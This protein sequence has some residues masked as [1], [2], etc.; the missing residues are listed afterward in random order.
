MKISRE[1]KTAILV[2]SGIALLIFL[3]NYLKGENLLDSSRTY[4]AVYDNVE[5]LAPS[6]PVTIN[7]QNVGKVQSIEFKEDGSGKLVVKLLITNDFEFSK[8]STAELYEAGLIGGK[9]VAIVPA[10][11]GASPA[12]SGSY[13]TAKTKEGLSELVNQR[14]TPLQE[15]I[16]M[17]MVSADE[18]IRNINSLFSPQNKENL[19]KAL[20]QL[21]GT[22]ISYKATANGLNKMIAD[23]QE[24]LQSTLSSAENTFGNFS[25]ISDSIAQVDL[26]GAARDLQSSMDNL[27]QLLS[28][29]EQGNGTMGKFLKDEQLYD[30]L[31]GATKQ[32]EELLQDL[33]LNPKRYVHFSVF[34]K[35]ADQYDAEG[36]LIKDSESKE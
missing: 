7:G 6:A 29:I 19:T 34:G 17:V 25:K 8:N 36:N 33:K 23:N 4:Y 21:E 35:K 11:D 15:K 28:G 22:I 24:S 3:F 14:L 1:V 26:A 18:A 20:A 5:G 32:L 31:E 2:I 16:E 12:K 27:N 9:A 10:F 30:N 13:L